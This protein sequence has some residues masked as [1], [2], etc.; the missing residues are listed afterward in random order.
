MEVL[1]EIA[2]IN[3]GHPLLRDSERKLY[4]HLPIWYP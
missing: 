1:E 4:K 3:Y 2:W